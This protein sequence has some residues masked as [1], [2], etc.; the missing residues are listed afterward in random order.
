MRECKFREDGEDE[1]CVCMRKEGLR[2]KEREREVR[3]LVCKVKRLETLMGF[4]T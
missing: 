4:R 1:E 2:E 3:Y